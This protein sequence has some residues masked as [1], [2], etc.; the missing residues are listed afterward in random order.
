V[1]SSMSVITLARDLAAPKT[2]NRMIFRAAIVV[3]TFSLIARLAGTAREIAV[4]GWFGRGPEVDALLIAFLVP[5]F[6]V[7]LVASSVNSAVI[8]IF[9]QARE[10]EG[11]EAAEQLLANITVC[12]VALLSGLGLLL[13][14]VAP[15]YL[16][17][18]GSGFS[19]EKLLLTR[20]LVYVFLPFILLGG[21][22]FTWISVLNAGERFAL[23]TLL[24]ALSPLGGIL[25]LFIGGRWCGIYALAIG[26]VLGQGVETVLL[27]RMVRDS[28]LRLSFIWHG[29]EG[30]TREVVGQYFPALA[31]ALLMSSTVIVDQAMAAMLAGGSVAALNYATKIVSVILNVSSGPLSAALLPY[32][33]RMVAAEDWDSCRHTLGT[34]ARLVLLVAIVVAAALVIFSRPLVK[35]LFEHGRFSAADTAAVSKVEALLA[36]QIPFYAMAVLGVRLLNVLRKNHYIMV[37]TAVNAVLNLLLNYILMK[38]MGLAGIALSTSIVYALSCGMIFA[39]VLVSLPKPKVLAMA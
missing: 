4:A 11:K 35:I 29:L 18:L 30:A 32:F 36:L 22:N 3:G 20:H 9:V 24:P 1:A 7:N 23:P 5:S 14:M 28:G 38:L 34:Y 19:A 13:G 25:C 10:R 31:G 27:A 17:L 39:C 2:M 21:L 16:P 26:L 12:S 37:I 8:P 33:S 15:Y 6:V